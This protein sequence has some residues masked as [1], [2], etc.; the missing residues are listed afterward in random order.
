V[1]ITF[2]SSPSTGQKFTSGNK[3]WTW[4]GNSWKG[5][6]SS[7]GD[8]G[9]LDSLNSTQFLRSDATMGQQVVLVLVQRV[10]NKNYILLKIAHS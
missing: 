8:A 1:A 7:G 6:V 10:H 5:G 4:D 3:V 9:T 2:P